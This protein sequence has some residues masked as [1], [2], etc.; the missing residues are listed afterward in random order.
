MDMGYLCAAAPFNYWLMQKSK[1]GGQSISFIV[2]PAM[3]KAL[4]VGVRAA[5]FY[6][7]RCTEGRH[8]T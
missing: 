8:I 5:A 3:E 6:G 4:T 1:N 2:R 7:A